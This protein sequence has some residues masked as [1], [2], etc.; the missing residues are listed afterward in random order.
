ML[1]VG[2]DAK[3]L[4]EGPFSHPVGHSYKVRTERDY[5]FI[6]LDVNISLAF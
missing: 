6:F 3:G 5:R 2:Y 1:L 4:Q